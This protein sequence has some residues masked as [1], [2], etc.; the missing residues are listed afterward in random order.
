MGM[1]TMKAYA[2]SVNL[3]ITDHFVKALNRKIFEQNKIPQGEDDLALVFEEIGVPKQK[4]L[5]QFRSFPVSN[6]ANQ[7]KQKTEDSKIQGVPAVV[8]N[9]KY[10]IITGSVKGEA[11]YFALV[12]YLL[13]LDKNH[14][15]KQEK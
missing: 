7:Y 9:N 12:Q 8:I 1:M 4:F 14:Y 10:Q 15:I 6:M 3:Q 11:E 2:V 13:N 5:A